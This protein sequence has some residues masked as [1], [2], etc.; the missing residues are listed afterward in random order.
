MFDSDF[1]IFVDCF[2]ILVSLIAVL[3]V[4]GFAGLFLVDCLKDF[5]WKHL[6]IRRLFFVFFAF[7]VLFLVDFRKSLIIC[8]F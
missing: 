6:K 1:R 3:Q 8:L 4:L 2:D 7:F 5:G